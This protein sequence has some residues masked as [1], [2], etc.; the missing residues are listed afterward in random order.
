MKWQNGLF[1]IKFNHGDDKMANERLSKLRRRL[2][3]AR[4]EEP[5][6][7]L[8]RGGRLVNVLSG[9]IESQ[10]VAIFDGVVIGF[11]VYEAQ[12]VLDISGAY[13]CPTFWDGHFH[14]ESSMLTPSELARVVVPLGTGAIVADPHEIANV[15][16]VE[17]I[18]FLLEASEHLPVD[19]YFML[20]SCVPA[21]T[22][23]TAGAEITVR[24]LLALKDHPRI[25]GLAEVMNFPGVVY[26]DES[27]L[28]KILAFEDRIKD[29]HAP[30]LT[31]KALNA[32]LTAGIASDHECSQLEEA[33]EKL[34]R[35]MYVMIREGT[36][37]R[38]LRDLITLVTP[39]NARRFILVTDDR[40]IED[41]L[42]RGHMNDLLKL[43]VQEGLDP[44]LAIQMAT[45]NTAEYFG[46]R[47][48]GAVAPGFSA[49]M[50][51]LKDLETFTT[52]IMIKK[53]SVVWS[54]G[55]FLA[56]PPTPLA[57]R[58][59]SFMNVAALSDTSFQ[60]RAAG[61]RAQIIDLVP[62]QIITRKMEMEVKTNHGL[63]VADPERDILKIAVVERHKGTGNVGLGLVRGFGLKHGALC[64]SVAH[65][66]HNLVVV[67]VSD[68]DMF[69][70]VQAV[71]AMKG[72]Q[73]AV[74]DGKVLAQLALPIAG[75][76][77]DQPA[78]ELISCR[79]ELIH[80]A[81]SIGCLLEDPY[82]TM[83]FLALPVI[84]SLKI[85]D[86]GLVD[87]DSFQF[88]SLFIP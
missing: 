29:G 59:L 55:A 13:V 2:A 53:G 33:R 49:D 78:D 17:G 87:V 46:I 5:A 81:R 9:A 84:P 39:R 54:Q 75:L 32:Y 61:T 27:L 51:V 50:V 15:W 76:M 47:H 66:S 80:A 57:E 71:M 63:V 8:L 7:L 35:G 25:I 21:T 67:G 73:V 31:G 83:S 34:S 11:G 12:E 44:V 82:M 68:V 22:M 28:R 30:L 16:G 86:R 38:N 45:L 74:C 23:E 58:P 26:A 77:S 62:G 70:A 85:T 79:T 19:F 56:K 65:D 37:A 10:D 43:A 72:G 42:T 88:T 36:A 6:D 41:L 3:V 24:D 64:S 52:K 4:G 60:I 20:P 48:N 1:D 40:H 18:R 69:N 14:L